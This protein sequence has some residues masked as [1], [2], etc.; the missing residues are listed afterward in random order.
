M[1]QEM[2]SSSKKKS[3]KTKVIAVVIA[4]AIVLVVG[5][6]N[7]ES[8]D[9]M[10]PKIASIFGIEITPETVSKPEATKKPEPSRVCRRHFYLS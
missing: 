3:M 7:H 2:G 8:F 10:L 9:T 4:I 5:F 1:V 6:L